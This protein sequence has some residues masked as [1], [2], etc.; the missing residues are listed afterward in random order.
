MKE[1]PDSNN[2]F[3]QCLKRYAGNK[4]PTT[5]IMRLA[6]KSCNDGTEKEFTHTPKEKIIVRMIQSKIKDIC[7]NLLQM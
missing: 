5:E 7:Q 6:A 4:I 3:T 2:K 1:A